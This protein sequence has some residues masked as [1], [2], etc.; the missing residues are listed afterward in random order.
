MQI[1]WRLFNNCNFHCSYCCNS[2]M[3]KVQNPINFDRLLR[4]AKS[5]HNLIE[6]DEDDVFEV[7][8]IGGE[9]TMLPLEQMKEIIN[10]IYSKKITKFHITSNMSAKVDYYIAINELCNKLNVTLKIVGSFHEEMMNYD[11][12]IKKARMLSD[13]LKLFIAEFVVTSENKEIYEK[14]QEDCKKYNIALMVDYNRKEK[15]ETNDIDYDNRSIKNYLRIILNPQGCICS[16]SKYMI[17]VLPHGEVYGTVCHNRKLLGM[18]NMI[19]SFPHEEFICKQKICSFCGKIEIK[20]PKQEILYSNVNNIIV[21]ED[22]IKKH[23]EEI[24]VI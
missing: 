10:T 4:I 20:T 15:W 14:I 22:L 7:N 21:N 23:N 3:N 24:N 13:N 6:K 12:F 11:V 8:L 19:K 16:N 17:N 5:I 18:I 1:K 2:V 9:I